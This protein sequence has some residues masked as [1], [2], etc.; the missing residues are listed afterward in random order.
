ML[1][2]RVVAEDLV[3]F[4]SVKYDHNGHGFL[5]Y[6]W[7]PSFKRCFFHVHSFFAIY[8]RRVSVPVLHGNPVSSQEIPAEGVKRTPD[9]FL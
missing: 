8:N 3:P 1:I 9:Y 6:P 2:Y 4:G 5:G 7:V